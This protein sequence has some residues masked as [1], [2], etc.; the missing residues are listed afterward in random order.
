MLASN[1]ASVCAAN[2]AFG[3][4]QDVDVRLHHERQAAVDEELRDIVRTHSCAST[5]VAA[6]RRRSWN[7]IF[8]SPALL[9]IRS[10]VRKNTAAIEWSSNS[11]GEDEPCFSPLGAGE[12]PLLALSKTIG[13]QSGDSDG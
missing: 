5:N 10:K 11:G 3:S 6:A 12:L 8:G 2:L 9:R 13:G 7:R 1:W 4:I